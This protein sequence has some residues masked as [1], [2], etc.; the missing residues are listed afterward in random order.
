MIQIPKLT[1]IA[2]SQELLT[3]LMA[4]SSC[5]RW[6][7]ASLS[8]TSR[9]DF[10]VISR[11]VI[12]RES[13]CQVTKQSP[14]ELSRPRLIVSSQFLEILRGQTHTCQDAPRIA[15]TRRSIPRIALA[16]WLASWTRRRSASVTVA[17]T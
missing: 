8:G 16:P 14:E 6:C 3:K 5:C 1:G 11:N 10:F 7:G 12:G 17:V 2:G 9:S 4:A 15:A 13:K